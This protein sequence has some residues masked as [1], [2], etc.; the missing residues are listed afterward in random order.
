MLKL[1]SNLVNIKLL[2]VKINWFNDKLYFLYFM[3]AAMTVS[4]LNEKVSSTWLSYCEMIF[5]QDFNS[6]IMSR[7]SNLNQKWIFNGFLKV[8]SWWLLDI[9]LPSYLFFFILQY[10]TDNTFNYR[11]GHSHLEKLKYKINKLWNIK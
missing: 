7:F 8:L 3:N 10:P 1:C 4:Q 9:M 5:N 2:L 11:V 6:L